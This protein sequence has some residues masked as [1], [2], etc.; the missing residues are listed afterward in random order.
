M[1]AAIL[2]RPISS[3]AFTNRSGG[4]N[5]SPAVPYIAS[6][7]GDSVANAVSD[8]LHGA[9]W[10]M[11][12]YSLFETYERTPACSLADSA[13]HAFLKHLPMDETVTAAPI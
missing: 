12:W 11:R 2:N 8:A 13:D 6:S 10:V 5:G 9:Q 1:S 3:E 7:V 4:I